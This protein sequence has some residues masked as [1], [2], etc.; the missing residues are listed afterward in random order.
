[1][2]LRATRS[3]NIKNEGGQAKKLNEG[4][5]L[6][7]T[8]DVKRMF[9][10]TIDRYLRKGWLEVSTAKAP[11]K[12]VEAPKEKSEDL[13]EVGGELAFGEVEEVKVEE[14]K[15]EEKPKAKKETKPKKKKAKSK[16]EEK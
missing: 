15:K 4:D 3:L 16:K 1:M 6:E 14:P 9:G 12:T 7:M 8:K 10:D 5:T 13:Y 11:K 2:K